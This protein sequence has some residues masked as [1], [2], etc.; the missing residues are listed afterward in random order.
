M[1]PYCDRS[2]VL[3]VWIPLVDANEANGC[4]WVIPNAHRD[5][6]ILTHIGRRNRWYLEIPEAELPPLERV[7]AP[8]KKRGALLLSNRTPHASFENTTDVTRWSMD[9]RYQSAA[10][11]TNAPITRL[12]G[13]AVEGE[14]VPVA[15]YPPEADMLVRS[16]ARPDEVVS[17][18]TKF[19]QIR[20]SHIAQPITARWPVV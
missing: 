4:M 5:G 2:L 12:G 8:V 7:C 15:C 3:T 17:S 16:R 11:P 10:L 14:H 9:L 1:E 18:A 19:E 13:E 20:K 6:T